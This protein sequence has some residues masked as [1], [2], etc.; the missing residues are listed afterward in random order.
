MKL[1]SELH[2]M[3]KIL[4]IKEDVDGLIGRLQGALNSC[5]KV[6]QNLG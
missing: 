6:E 3:A 4:G 2:K 1:E 5:K